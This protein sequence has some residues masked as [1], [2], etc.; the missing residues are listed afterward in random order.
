MLS[1]DFL[2]HASCMCRMCR[3]GNGREAIVSGHVAVAT[4]SHRQKADAYSHIR[5]QLHQMTG[6]S[7][8]I[9]PPCCLAETLTSCAREGNP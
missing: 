6:F 3:K 9:R 5:G 4:S 2:A 8:S 7:C 1:R